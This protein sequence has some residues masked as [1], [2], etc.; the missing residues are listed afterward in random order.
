MKR[1]QGYEENKKTQHVELV[2][3]ILQTRA[4]TTTPHRRR[5][6]IAKMS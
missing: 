5:F 6:R 1:I 2:R 3:E 4:L